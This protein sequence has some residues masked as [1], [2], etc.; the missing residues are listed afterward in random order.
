MGGWQRPFRPRIAV[1]LLSALIA[2]FASQTVFAEHAERQRP[3]STGA[4]VPNKPELGSIGERLNANTIA[5]ISGNV[6]ATYLT[7]AYDLS[8]VLDNGDEFRVLPVI[9]KG[10]GQNVKD[11][12]Y[13]KGIDL[14]IT[15]SNLLNVYRRTGEIGNIDDKIVYIT[16]LF[17]EEM[18]LIVRSDSDITSIDQL[19]GKK[20]NFS[21]IGSGTQLASRDIFQRLGIKVQEVNI[22]QADAVEQL[23][24]GGIAATILIA[25][26]PAASMAKLKASEGFRVLPVPFRKELQADYLPATLTGADY[27]GLV[28][29]DASVDTIACGA[30]LIAY[31]WPK[32]S[33]RYRRIQTF[34]DNFFPKLAEFQKAPRHPKWKETNLAAVLPGWTR[35]DGAE[36]WL[37]QQPQAQRDQF[38]RFVAAKRPGATPEERDQLFKDFVQWRNAQGSSTTKGSN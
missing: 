6:N 17:N 31:N 9:G 30:V 19:A 4:P 12:R 26:K 29:K 3:P 21:D 7:I 35:F 14:G 34:V 8:A 24:S 11:V 16:K 5:I 36:E 20:V 23:K 25:G 18:H 1:V 10:G 22:G 13:L 27:P 32:G 33:D 28:D 2:L 15:Q 38:D 37:K